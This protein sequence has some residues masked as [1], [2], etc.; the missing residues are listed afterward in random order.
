M[1]DMFLAGTDTTATALEWAMA[2][3]LKHPKVMIQLQNEIRGVNK[4]GEDILTEE[5]LVDMHYLKAV[6]NE[7]LRLHP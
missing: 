2:E 3:I 7:S 6:I 4:A 1:Q 5:D